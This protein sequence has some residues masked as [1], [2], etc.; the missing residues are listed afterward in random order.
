M[1][2]EPGDEE[3]LKK[4]D[5]YVVVVQ[6]HT[7]QDDTLWVLT[8][9]APNCAARGGWTRA[10]ASG[11]DVPA[12]AL[13]CCAGGPCDPEDGGRWMLERVQD[14]A[15]KSKQI[16]KMNVT[17][18]SVPGVDGS[19]LRRYAAHCQEHYVN[20]H[21]RHMYHV[22]ERKVWQVGTRL[23]GSSFDN[24]II[25]EEGTRLAGRHDWAHSNGESGEEV[26][27]SLVV[28]VVRTPDYR[29]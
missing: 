8:K 18:C 2:T 12:G 17:G 26:G 14:I 11:R 22:H 23:F 21:G 24:L 25:R 4:Q 29:M 5:G 3:H 7:D 19:Y 1:Y 27:G 6:E 10:K 15:D 20:E 16:N 9:T 28:T 13:A